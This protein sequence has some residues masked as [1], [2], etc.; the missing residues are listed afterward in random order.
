MERKGNISIIMHRDGTASDILQS[1]IHA[2][3]EG[4]LKMDHSS[5]CSESQS[6]MDKNYRD[7][8]QEVISVCLYLDMK[9]I[10]TE[11]LEPV[12]NKVYQYCS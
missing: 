10:Y 1:F 5:G 7:F 11:Q 2:L 12:C 6:W 3:V 8:L 9:F 4:H